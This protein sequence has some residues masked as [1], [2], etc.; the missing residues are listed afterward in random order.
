VDITTAGSTAGNVFE[1]GVTI[2]GA[3]F[4]KRCR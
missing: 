4:P 1:Q 3:G 2:A